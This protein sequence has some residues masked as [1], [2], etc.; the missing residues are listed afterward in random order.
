MSTLAA[1][2]VQRADVL[3][4]RV[5]AEMYRDPFWET[6]FGARGRHFAEEDGRYHVT[7]LAQALIA[8]DPEVLTRYAGWLRTVLVSR[9][10]CTRHLIENYQRLSDA[11]VESGLPD[12]EPAVLYLEHAVEALRY[13]HGPALL[14]QRLRGRDDELLDFLIDAVAA[15]RPD[16]FEQH[17]RY[18]IDHGAPPGGVIDSLETLAARVVAAEPSLLAVTEP[19]FARAVAAVR[20]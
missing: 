11:I 10:M 4:A 5:V 20:R 13:A 17:V 18:C 1:E 3:S 2:L 15:D 16:L 6:R 19:Y 14:L 8:S 7:Y 9:G 12:V